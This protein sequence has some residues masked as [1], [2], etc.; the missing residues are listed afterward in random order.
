MVSVQS[1]TAAPATSSELAQRLP[2]QV[3][4]Q[5]DFLKLLAVQF[6]SQD[7]LKPMEDTAFIAQMASFSALEIQ[8]DMSSSL[9]SLSSSQQLSAAQL[10]LGR[11]VD[12]IG[13]DNQPV[14]ATVSAVYMDGKKT[15][16]TVNNQDY[17]A[18]SVSRIRINN[19]TGNPSSEN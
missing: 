10:L 4:G 14:S 17:D 15:M 16:I 12:L 2:K 7:P 19:P 8:N 13:S 11:Q 9:D 6:S 1:T 18:S 5:E 3:L